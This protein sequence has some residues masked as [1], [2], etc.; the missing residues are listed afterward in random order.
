MLCFVAQLCPT[1]CDP[2]DCSLSSSFV[3]GDSP[4]KNTG[5]GCHT[6]LQGIF[7]A[8]GS[9]LGL[10]HFRKILHH[11]SHQESPLQWWFMLNIIY[12]TDLGDFPGGPVIKT[13]HFHC[14]GP[15]F[16]P[17]SGNQNP[18]YHMAQQRKK[19]ER[20][21]KKDWGSS[22][23]S[24]LP[25]GQ[26]LNTFWLG[27]FIKIPMTSSGCHEDPRR[28]VIFLWWCPNMELISKFSCIL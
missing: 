23:G 10:Q 27:F 2:M 21:K 3:H 19:K 6:L 4:G 7:P 28:R 11:L 5:V 16:H 25:L 12:K 15:G 24:A 9:N 22:P 1:L 18:T 26:S 8:Q 13:P 14:R 20:K 17:W